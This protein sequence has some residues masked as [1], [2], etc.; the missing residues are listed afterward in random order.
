MD[1]FD[2]VTISESTMELVNPSTTEKILKLGRALR[3]QEG[4]RVIDFGCGYA[5]P[6]VLWAEAYGI[7]GVG[8]DIRQ[9]ACD[10][11]RQKVTSRGLA[12]RIEIVCASGDEYIFEPAAFDAATCIGA[13]FIWGGF[14]PTVRAMKR[15]IKKG[16]RLGVGEPYWRHANVPLEVREQDPEIAFEPD[17]VRAARD[18]GFDLETIIRASHDDWDRYESDDWHGLILWLEENPDHPERKQV[19]DH[20]RK[21]Q[22]EYF[23]YGREH[24]G[25]AMFVLSPS[26]G[27]PRR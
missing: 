4:S 8:I 10:R 24:L 18:E 9:A 7:S 27:E 11:A 5:E 25:W 2:L 20:L 17:F 16:G 14:Q 23:A 26:A 21:M 1:F 6:L 19:Y 12:D 22:D 13:T 3:L 15:A